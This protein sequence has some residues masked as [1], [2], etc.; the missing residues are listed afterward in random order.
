MY[1]RYYA[2]AETEGDPATLAH[3]I[4]NSANTNFA[5][6]LGSHLQLY[7]SSA[8]QSLA[9]FKTAVAAGQAPLNLNNDYTL[10][11][12]DILIPAS[13]G[14]SAATYRL[15]VKRVTPK[16]AHFV[17]FQAGSPLTELDLDNSNNYALFRSQEIEDD[18]A[19]VASTS[20]FVLTLAAM[21]AA[22]S[23]SGDFV[24]HSDTQNL[25]NK[26]FAT[27]KGNS[28]DCGGRSWSE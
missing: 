5:W 14:L 13:Y 4:S 28:Y 7:I 3:T 25:E 2:T 15:H 27:N 11:G 10:T 8:G 20:T 1:S 9:D 21:K 6:L 22:A 16:D 26:T 24:G 23:V 19:V 18:L 12:A 17:N